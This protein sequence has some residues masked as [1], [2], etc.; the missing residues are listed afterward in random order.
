MAREI[1]V[2]SVIK[3]PDN[4]VTVGGV[5]WLAAPTNRV[6]PRPGLVSQVPLAS[7][8]TWGITTGELAALQAG[9]TV[10]QSFSFGV[11]A[12]VGAAS[13]EASLQTDYATQQTALT[14]SAPGA[15]FVGASWDGTTWTAAT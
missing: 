2:T 14:N 3:N 13:I 5:Y 15:K 9:T 1:I 4:S 8:V 6:I 10:E 7:A 12:G 11:A